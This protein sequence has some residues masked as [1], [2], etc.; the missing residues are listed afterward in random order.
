MACRGSLIL[1]DIRIIFIPTE[2]IYPS[3]MGLS[4][5]IHEDGVPPEYSEEQKLLIR[6][7]TYIIPIPCLQDIKTGSAGSSD[8]A[9]NAWISFYGRD[10]SAV[11]FQVHKQAPSKMTS[12]QLY[13]AGLRTDEVAPVVWCQRVMD[14]INW[15]LKEG[16]TWVRFAKL[17]RQECETKLSDVSKN[18]MSIADVT[19][20]VDIGSDFRRLRA[21]ED[22]EWEPS[23]LNGQYKLCSTYPQSL[24]FPKSMGE[25]EVSLA[26]KVRSRN[27]LAALSWVHP[28]TGIPL[29]RAA[30][31]KTGKILCL[32][33]YFNSGLLVSKVLS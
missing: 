23:T 5:G 3:W 9:G 24:Y 21:T 28:E 8:A 19:Q 15:R 16:K 26:A 27:R 22:W 7:L 18:F 6:R 25:A 14:E 33:H 2:A 29:T 11:E 20:M 31:P 1:T 32:L 12:Y 17:F 10:G 30:Q 13:R 4:F